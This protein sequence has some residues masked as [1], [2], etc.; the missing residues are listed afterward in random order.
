MIINVFGKKLRVAGHDVQGR[1]AD[2]T[3]LLQ[4]VISAV[5]VVNPLLVKILSVSALK[6]KMIAILKQLSKLLN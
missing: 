1:V 4:E 2:I 6:M 5:R 3:A